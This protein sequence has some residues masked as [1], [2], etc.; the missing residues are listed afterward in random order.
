MGQQLKGYPSK[1]ILMQNDPQDIHVTAEPIR[2]QQHGLTTLAHMFV[3]LIVDDAVEADSTTTQINATA[4]EAL[5]GDVISFTSGNL[6]TRQVKVRAID[7][8]VIYLAQELTEAPQ[9]GDTFDIL[10]HLYP[11]LTADGN[12]QTTSSNVGFL[13]DGVSVSVT[14]DTVDPSNN[15]PLPVKLTGVTG[16]VN[17]TAGDLD[18]DITAFGANPSSVRIADGTNTLVVN[19]DGSVNAV[20]SQ[21]TGTNLHTVVDSGTLVV[22]QGT[23]TNLHAV[24]DSGTITANAGTGDFTVVQA[25]GTNLHTVVDSGSITV[26]QATGTNLHAV[27]DSGTLEVT[28]ATGTNLHTVVD[29]G[30][31]VVT[32]ATGT[33]L[34]V[35]V[36]SGNIVASIGGPSVVQFVRNDYSSVNVT[37]SAYVQ[38]IASTTA[39]VLRLQIFDSSGQTLLLA[40]GGSGS[41]VDQFYIFPGGNGEVS[42]AI[43]SGSR[44]SVKAVSAT[45]N[46][47]ELTINLLG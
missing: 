46:V 20:V 38:L 32:Q 19:A 27:V 30:T 15:I 39:D 33:N 36:D 3:T 12:I 40:V 34:H 5:V 47:G 28:Q 7:T 23:G 14:E 1:K 10:R 17:I 31:L 24:I 16:D 11:K 43:A 25:T 6:D 18:V 29:S 44:I 26:T 13:K 4:H 8:D 21:A 9:T 2:E 35:V 37:T 45:A 41:E 22:T 42:H